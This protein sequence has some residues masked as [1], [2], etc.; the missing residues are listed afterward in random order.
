MPT[1]VHRPLKITAFNA[2]GI[3]RQAYEVRKQLQDLKID[4]ALFS[5]MQLKPHMRFCIRNYD[6]YWTDCEDGHKD[7]TAIA[8]KIGI[9]HTCV[10]LLSLLSAEATGVCMLTGNTEMFLAAVYKSPQRLWMT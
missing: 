9:L 6:F 1:T 5:E 10:D 3:G 7:G 2:N 4:V 8:V